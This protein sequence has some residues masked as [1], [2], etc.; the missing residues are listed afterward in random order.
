MMVREGEVYILDAKEIAT[1]AAGCCYC[2]DCQKER[3]IIASH[4]SAI[5]HSFLESNPSK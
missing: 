5:S 1:A 3:E 2:C 4:C